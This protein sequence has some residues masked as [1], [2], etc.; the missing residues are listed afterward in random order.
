LEPELFSIHLWFD[1]RKI[2]GPADL[3]ERVVR[4]FAKKRLD[5]RH[6]VAANLP[7][8]FHP[9]YPLF[10]ER[11]SARRRARGDAVS[12]IFRIDLKAIEILRR[13]LATAEAFLRQPTGKA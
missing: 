5:T 10:A 6:I 11:P 13:E 12:V 9:I 8:N 1:V 4:L 3:Q 2:S 7:F